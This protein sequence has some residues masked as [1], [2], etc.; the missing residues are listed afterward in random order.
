MEPCIFSK[1]E[2]LMCCQVAMDK[3]VDKLSTQVQNLGERICFGSRDQ[4]AGACIELQD[5]ANNLDIVLNGRNVPWNTHRRARKLL[6]EISYLADL[7]RRLEHSDM[8]SSLRAVLKSET[9]DDGWQ[10][11]LG[12]E[13]LFYDMASGMKSAVYDV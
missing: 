4:R 9:T 5:V 12:I 10:A 11:Y 13:A 6:V 1:L 8:L 3:M 2:A 7:A